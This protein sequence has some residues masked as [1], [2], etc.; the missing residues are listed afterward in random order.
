MQ[1]VKYEKIELPTLLNQSRSLCQV[2]TLAQTK[3]GFVYVEIE[4]A[5]IHQL[6]PLLTQK[7]LKATKPPYFGPGLTGAHISLIYPNEQI[8][9]P[10]FEL[11]KQY[12]FTIKDLVRARIVNKYYYV[13]LVSSPALI[14]LRQR[15]N[16]PEKLDFKGYEIDLHI[17]IANEHT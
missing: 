8:S 13:L 6:Y 7:F 3:S 1:P 9:I 15:Y 16:L 12:D 10:N 17:T 14:K 2:G 11:E 5:Y 4:D